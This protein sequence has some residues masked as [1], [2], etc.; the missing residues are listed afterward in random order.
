MQSE[1]NHCHFHRLTLLCVTWLLIYPVKAGVF[2]FAGDKYGT[3]I[4]THPTGYYG[5]GGT[6]TVTVGI[7]PSS[8]FISEM[9][10]PLQNAIKT[11]NELI[12]TTGNIIAPAGDIPDSHYDFE[13]VV[14]HELG[15]CLG[16]SHPNLASES[17]LVEGDKDYTATTKGPNNQF[18][19]NS[20]PDGVI[21]SRDDIRGDDVNL[22]WF[23]K[24]S[25]NPFILPAIIDKTTYSQNLADLPANDQYVAN[26]DRDVSVLFGLPKTEAV[27]QQGIQEREARRTLTADDVATLR[28]A[29]SGLDML[30][31]TKDDYKVQLQYAGVTDTA[32]IVI[33]FDDQTAFAACAISG[34]YIG[35]NTTHLEVVSGQIS[36]NTG[37]AW[38]FNQQPTPVAM[39]LP[40]LTVYANHQQKSITLAQG[41]HLTLTISLDPTTSGGSLADYWVKAETPMGTFWL[42]DQFQF[43]ASD[44]P[45]RAYGGPLVNIDSFTLFDASTANLPPGTYTIRFAV[46]GNINAIY[47]GTYEQL[48][49]FTINP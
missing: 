26:G 48:I 38:H 35:F 47:D 27:M 4:I 37:F 31:D 41:E 42:N 14:L 44:N 33:A 28:L 5:K 25:N 6:L 19:L 45:L 43:E 40:V 29:M 24:G 9:V 7:S 49:T 3:Q 22:H 46:D 17:G 36:L 2:E 39:Q 10:T 30:Q 1:F 11:W 18:D 15:H 21:G 13:S 8:P 16:L 12:P 23:Y 32:D 20:G 34:Q